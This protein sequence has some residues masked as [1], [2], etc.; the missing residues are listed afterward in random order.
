MC[1]VG[2]DTLLI[3]LSLGPGHHHHRGQDITP[4]PSL[5]KC[6]NWVTHPRARH[7]A[8]ATEVV[9]I[10][11]LSGSIHLV[12]QLMDVTETF[13]IWFQSLAP[14]G[15]YKDPHLDDSFDSKLMKV[16][17]KSFQDLDQQ[18]IQREPKPCLHEA[19]INYHLVSFG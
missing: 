18:F 8:I 12:R 15:P 3:L 10:L 2:M 6:R 7:E 19:S 13:C 11:F 5:P 17:L 4:R 14:H 16:N 1:L 9:V